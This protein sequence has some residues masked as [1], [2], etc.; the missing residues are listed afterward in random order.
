MGIL[1]MTTL[2]IISKL[3]NLPQHNALLLSE[4][5]ALLLIADATYMTLESHTFNCPCYALKPDLETRGLLTRLM[6]QYQPVDY[7]GFVELTECHQ[8]IIHW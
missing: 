3:N 6:P 8:Q 2:H 5:D 7:T 4:K 1:A